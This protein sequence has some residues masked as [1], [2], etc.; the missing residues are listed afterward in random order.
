MISTAVWSRGSDLCGLIGRPEDARRSRRR[1]PRA[2][3]QL[4]S[5]LRPAQ[6]SWAVLGLSLS[7]K[8]NL[9]FVR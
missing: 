8:C 1:L 9:A 2:G 6:L 4:P 5:V 7:S 3:P